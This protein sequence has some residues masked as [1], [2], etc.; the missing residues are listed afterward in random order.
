MVP[1][2]YRTTKEGKL[3]KFEKGVPPTEAVIGLLVMGGFVAMGF[4]VL[5][6][7]PASLFLL[8][9]IPVVLSVVGWCLIRQRPDVITLD[10][11]TDSLID[12]QRIL[13]LPSEIDRINLYEV[14]DGES[15]STWYTGAILKDGE[16]VRIAAHSSKRSARHMGFGMARHLSV[17]LTT[18]AHE[19]TWSSYLLSA[20]IFLLV[21]VIA[22]W[23]GCEGSL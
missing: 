21:L 9:A 19:E 2:D 15:G 1:P 4:V 22:Y 23:A 8:L 18:E 16:H 5:L 17:S 12:G 11:S 14:H 13:C 20:L 3:I 7:P 6:R 10:K